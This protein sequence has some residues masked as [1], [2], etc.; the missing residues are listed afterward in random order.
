MLLLLIGL[1]IGPRP[2]KLASSAVLEARMRAHSP[3]FAERLGC[4]E[5]LRFQVL[6][7][8][9]RAGKPV[10][11]GYRVDAEYFYPASAIKLCAAIAAL[12]KFDELRRQ[13]AELALDTPLVFEPCFADS[14]RFDLDPSNREGGR[15][16]LRHEIR[17]LCLVSDNPAFNHLYEFVGQQELNRRM[18]DGG[19][20]SVRILHRLSESRTLEENR[21]IP[22]VRFLLG[23]E[24]FVTI[25]ARRGEPLAD[26]RGIAGL[27]IGQAWM[28][29][30]QRVEE[31]MSFREKNRISLVDLQG[32]LQRLFVSKGFRIEDASR[33]LLLEAMT[34]YPA[35]SPN[36]QYARAEYPDEWGKPFLPGLERIFP[37]EEWKIANKIGVAYGFTVDNA[38]I[39]NE[40]RKLSFFLT[41]VV[42]TNADGVL[43]D[44]RYEYRTVAKPLFAD[45]AEV[46]AQLV[47]GDQPR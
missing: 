47:L 15:P 33:S 19:L 46:A 26:N 25:P 4:A 18:R 34:Q 40:K 3:A 29:G 31:P 13:Y 30:D 1:A 16:T 39:V 9:E 5:E 2:D 44:N 42:Y 37:K 12:E 32:M 7:S 35:D 22:E 41:A 45:L 27:E 8:F 10:R 11:H 43:N 36:P 21:S 38:W 6:L 24:R 23:E 20:A 17:K 14:V 28:R